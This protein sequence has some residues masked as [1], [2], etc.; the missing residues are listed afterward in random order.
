MAETVRVLAMAGIL[1]ALACWINFMLDTRNDRALLSALAIG[2]P[3]IVFH[4]SANLIH[5][6]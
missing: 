5:Q 2:I 1:L 3:S 6:D 4:A